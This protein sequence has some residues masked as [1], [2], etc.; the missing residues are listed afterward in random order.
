MTATL[1]APSHSPDLAEDLREL[2][3]L[4]A[5]ITRAMRERYAVAFEAEGS[6]RLAES[7]RADADRLDRAWSRV[8]RALTHII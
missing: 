8:D 6:H 5:T 1:T 2:R 4:M 7:I 3:W